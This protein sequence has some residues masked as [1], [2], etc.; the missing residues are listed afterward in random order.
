MYPSIS[1]QPRDG[2]ATSRGITI[3]EILVALAI[4]AV[5]ISPVMDL[6]LQSFRSNEASI[7]EIVFT[8]LANELV[9]S[10][11]NGGRSFVQATMLSS[12]S[13]WKD[14]LALGDAAERRR[15]LKSDP[16]LNT[17]EVAFKLEAVAGPPAGYSLRVRVKWDERGSE[18]TLG[19]ARF[20]V[21]R[22]DA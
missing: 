5:L 3:V 16:P 22:E 18:R 1:I 13:D 15:Y 6:V 20:F 14:L 11:V 21:P 17:R 12:G 7:N 4:L 2:P 8:N 10:L 19:L 9:D